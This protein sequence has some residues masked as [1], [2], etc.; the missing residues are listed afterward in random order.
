M[1]NQEQPDLHMTENHFHSDSFNKM[2]PMPSPFF[3][4]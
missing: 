4:N 1:P 2:N 3:Q